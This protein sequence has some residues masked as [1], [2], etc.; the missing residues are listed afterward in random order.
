MSVC[1][2]LKNCKQKIDEIAFYLCMGELDGTT[3]HGLYDYND[4]LASN[5]LEL[6]SDI[7]SVRKTAKEWNDYL[8][9]EEKDGK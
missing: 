9:E 2:H 1:P 6:A 7:D 3:A 4:C 5:T 8:G